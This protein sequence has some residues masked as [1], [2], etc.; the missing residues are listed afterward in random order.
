MNKDDYAV[1]TIVGISLFAIILTLLLTKNYKIISRFTYENLFYIK[2]YLWI[3]MILVINIGLCILVYYSSNLSVMIYIILFLKLKDIIMV[4]L[5]VIINLVELCKYISNKLIPN[6]VDINNKNVIAFIPAY[7][8]SL[9][10]VKKTVDS[11]INNKFNN[12]N[13]KKLI[14]IVSDGKN[15]YNKIY[16]NNSYSNH[17]YTYVSW[18]KE[19]V[20]VDISYGFKDN[21][22]IMIIHKQENIG[23][24]DSIILVNMLFNSNTIIRDN[25]NM[26]FKNDVL[27]FEEFKNGG[28]LFA[29]G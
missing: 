14:C 20:N 26:K 1:I 25:I 10:D 2:K 4:I 22:K 6:D 9:F 17:T 12:T 16:D 19:C 28:H 7:T 21:N 29:T 13:N 23:K 8:E 24:K 27:N 11:V 18:L 5:F 3:L 15:Y